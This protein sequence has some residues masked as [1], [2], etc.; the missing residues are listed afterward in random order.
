[1]LTAGYERPNNSCS[2]AMLMATRRASS[3][4]SAPACILIGP[5]HAMTSMGADVDKAARL[6]LKQ[7]GFAF[8]NQACRPG[9]EEHPLGPILII[10]FAR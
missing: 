5:C 7:L 2:R 3:S 9:E 1:M 4:V 10:P 6:K 8:E